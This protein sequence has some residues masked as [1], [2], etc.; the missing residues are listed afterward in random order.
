MCICSLVIDSACGRT[1]CHKPLIIIETNLDQDSAIKFLIRTLHFHDKRFTKRRAM[2]LRTC[3]II[4]E[5][6]YNV[7]LLGDSKK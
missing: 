6:I 5:F 3:R 4:S 1:S 7:D 2:N